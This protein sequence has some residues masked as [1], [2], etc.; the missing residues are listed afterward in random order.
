MQC[1]SSEGCKKLNRH[2]KSELDSLEVCCPV[3]CKRSIPYLEIENHAADW[4]GIPI[5]SLQLE[6]QEED[7][8]DIK[9]A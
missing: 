1:R 6:D 7:E 2:L 5:E 8:K 9:N 3:G 4:D